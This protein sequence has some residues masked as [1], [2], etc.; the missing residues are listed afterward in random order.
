M[1]TKKIIFVTGNE[2]KLNEAKDILE[3]FEIVNKNIDLDELQGDAEKI[4]EKKVEDA[5][6]LI[7]KPCFV[8]DTSFEIESLNG[9]PGPY[10]KFFLNKMTASGIY[11]MVKNFKNKKVQVRCLIGYHDGRI[12]KTFNVVVK[13]KIVSPKGKQG[14]GFDS[15]F[16]PDGYDKTYA[17][18][19]KDEKNKISHRRKVL[20]KF[21]K[22]LKKN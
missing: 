7:K 14:F 5:F 6:K 3:N 11:Q 17:Q 16:M 12:V 8:D 9:L 4:I 22:Y 20:K 19:H 18:M 21:L 13:G 10:I 15:I 1:K 2:N